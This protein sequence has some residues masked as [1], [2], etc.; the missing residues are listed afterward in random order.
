MPI[1][2]EQKFPIS[3][4]VA[5]QRR[6]ATLV[7][8]VGKTET[9]AD[10]YYNHPARDFAKTDEA[11]R[12]RRVGASNYF[13]YKGPKLDEATKTRREIEIAIGSGEPAAAEAGEM[14]EALG[15]VPVATVRKQRRH[16]SVS[17]QGQEVLV[18]LDKVEELGSFVE[19]EIIATEGQLDKARDCLMS[20]AAHLGL[21]NA[22]R[23]SYLELLL[24]R[25]S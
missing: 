5:F 22:E 23:R 24:E 12:I 6:L 21:A 15:F 11:L 14:L 20:L 13:T 2:V 1:E 3:D 18:A 25:G 9:Q 7:P 19:L 4:P 8:V 16:A 17:W 10:S